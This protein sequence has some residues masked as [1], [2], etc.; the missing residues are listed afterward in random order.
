MDTDIYIHTLLTA[1]NI[2]L[3]ADVNNSIHVLRFQPD[4]QVLS[5]VSRDFDFRTPFTASF[6]VDGVKLGYVGKYPFSFEKE[7]F[8]SDLF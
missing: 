3:A 2:I 4:M 6:F 5:L 7:K 8:G 1:N